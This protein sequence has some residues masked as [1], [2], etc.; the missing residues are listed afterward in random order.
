MQLK[1][2]NLVSVFHVCDL[3]TTM[4]PNAKYKL[5]FKDFYFDCFFLFDSAIQD[6]VKK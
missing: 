6:V 2:I 5:I 1:S 4:I 3:T